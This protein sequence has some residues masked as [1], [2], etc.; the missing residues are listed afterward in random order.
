[1][2]LHRSEGFGLTM[3]E[4]MYLGKPVI[5]T[6]YSGNLDFMTDEN[7]YLVDYE[8]VPIGADA[9]PYPP[10]GEWA[11]PDVEHAARLMRRVFE[12]QAESR[13]RGARAASAIRETH[14]A[15]T[16]G[17][18]MAERLDV[19]RRMQGEQRRA[20]VVSELPATVA[21]GPVAP[22][23]SSAGP[24]GPLLRRA[25][26]RLMKPLSAY[27]KTI[28]EQLIR[29][30][31]SLDAEVAR[32]EAAQQRAEAADLAQ[33]RSASRELLQLRHDVDALTALHDP[34]VERL[35]DLSRRVERIEHDA[36]R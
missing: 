24:V 18:R 1:V 30:V 11:E 2:S 32:I 7:S 26:L 28:N 27:Q 33:S 17:A 34:I 15:A 4:A 31:Q 29:S 12:D 22:Q 25:A 6:A 3:A 13:D 14:S 16:A 20:R 21:R 5:A 36:G 8:L 10:G 23:R 35:D 19:V 9:A